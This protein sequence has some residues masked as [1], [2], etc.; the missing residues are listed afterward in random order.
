MFGQGAPLQ[1]AMKCEAKQV[2]REF[3]PVDKFGVTT[4]MTSNLSTTSPTSTSILAGVIDDMDSFLSGCPSS[5]NAPLDKT[6][7]LANQIH[8][9]LVRCKWTSRFELGH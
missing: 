5:L 1:R 3:C 4:G 9:N 2:K 8:V 7:P 6:L